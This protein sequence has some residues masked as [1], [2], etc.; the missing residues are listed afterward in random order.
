MC[1]ANLGY[2][3]QS[4]S[5]CFCFLLVKL[6][7]YSIATIAEVTCYAHRLNPLLLPLCGSSSVWRLAA[8]TACVAPLS[9]AWCRSCSWTS[10]G[11]SPLP[12]SVLATAPQQIWMR[13]QP[14]CLE[15]LMQLPQQLQHQM[16]SQM[17]C[18]MCPCLGCS[19][20]E[21]CFQGLQMPLPCLQSLRSHRKLPCLC[22]RC[23]D[24][25][26]HY[27]TEA[28]TVHQVPVLWCKTFSATSYRVS[29]Q[30]SI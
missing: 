15:P 1:Q 20:G 10:R 14:A 24:F 6:C 22:H 29:Y 8:C 21:P 11:T 18:C 28:N 2:H 25:P 9:M 13:R 23:A 4:S 27:T 12:W 7:D 30:Q 17:A 5:T 3:C 19:K 16:L 26:T